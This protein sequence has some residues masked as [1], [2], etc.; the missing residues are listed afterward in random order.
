[1]KN[2]VRI[3]EIPRL[4]TK[5]PFKAQTFYKWF[6]TGK[7]LEIFVKISGALFLDLERLEQLIDASRGQRK[8][9]L[10]RKKK[11]LVAG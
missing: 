4:P 8:T 3:S 1:M 10:P 9:P 2:L 5:L 7:H 11:P 6:H